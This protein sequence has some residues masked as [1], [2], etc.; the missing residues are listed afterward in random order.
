ML[1]DYHTH[2]PL[3]RHAEGWP[4]E[5]AKVAIERGLDELGFADHNPMAEPFDDWRMLLGDLPRYFEAIEEARAAYPQLPI[6]LGL[7]VDYIAGHETWIEHLTEAAEW[8]FL[9]GSVHYIAEGWD[10]DNPKHISRYQEGTVETIWEMYWKAYERCIRSGL[11]DFVAH[12]DL[13][14]K[15]GF[16]PRGDLRRY[17][18]PVVTAMLETGVA[19]EINTAGL[20]KPVGECYPSLEFLRLAHSAGIGLLINSDAHAPSEVGAG[21]EVALALAKEAGY[22]QLVRFERRKRRLVCI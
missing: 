2:T 20:R 15:F 7:E 5:Y 16:R 21:F 13:P 11:F 9:I 19:F 10:I 4:I 3:C 22:R 6:R 1:T 12:P 17:Y 14:K 8:D 18:E